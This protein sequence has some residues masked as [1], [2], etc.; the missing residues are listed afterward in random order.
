VHSVGEKV[1][2]GNLEVSVDALT[3]R[4]K[5]GASGFSVK[6]SEGGVYVAIEWS[7]KNVSKEPIGT[8]SQPTIFLVSPEGVK[9]EPDIDASSSFA[10]EQELDEK[11][12]SDLN[13]G[14]KVRGA[15]VF[16]VAEELFKIGNW[17]I[18]IEG[19]DASI[20]FATP[21]N[22][23]ENSSIPG[24]ATNVPSSEQAQDPTEVRAQ[25]KK[26]DSGSTGDSIIGQ[27]ISRF[28]PESY[29]IFNKDGT[30]LRCEPERRAITWEVI[31]EGKITMNQEVPKELVANA[32]FSEVLVNLFYQ[33]DGDVMTAWQEGVEE[34][35]TTYD[36]S[37]SV[38]KSKPD[39][40]GRP[41]EDSAR[42]SQEHNLD[43]EDLA[44]Q[45]EPESQR[46]PENSNARSKVK[47]ERADESDKM[48][49]SE[50][51]SE[52]SIKVKVAE[53]KGE[54]AVIEA[55]IESERA[56]WQA[57]VDTINQL[58]NFKKSP[59]RE[60]S[61][62]YHKCME[63]SKIINEVEA[64][65]PKLKSEKAKLEAIINELSS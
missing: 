21:E 42:S 2:A 34:Y 44:K 9:Y 29:I 39:K 11:I 59:V 30:G 55:K 28:N 43:L 16:E 61:L 35:K 46:M 14:I 3:V 37:N 65:A 33:I 45:K 17:K 62:Q 56:R 31:E 54:L 50:D 53:S 47:T 20:W 1:V 4:S 7:C 63:A 51:G 26:K 23:T 41:P 58:T 32:G 6:A 24:I 18:L 22:I 40:S 60:G 38:P 36:R 12:L 10:T 27:W 13:P 49:E 57:A 8:F 19:G 15:E 5:V 52:D 25:D 64:G 48:L